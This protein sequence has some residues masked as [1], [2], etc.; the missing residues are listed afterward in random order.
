[1][2]STSLINC[3]FSNST[4]AI[5]QY[6]RRR[7]PKGAKPLKRTQSNTHQATTDELKNIHNPETPPAAG[8]SSC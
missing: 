8:N 3:C 2:L 4:S 6:I 7:P 1:M 5:Q